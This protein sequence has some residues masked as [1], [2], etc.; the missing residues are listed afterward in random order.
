MKK[1]YSNHPYN[2]SRY[3]AALYLLALLP[4]CKKDIKPALPGEQESAAV[5]YYIVSDVMN[6]AYGPSRGTTAA[7]ADSVQQHG[8]IIYNTDSRYPV[9]AF[10]FLANP[11]YPTVNDVSGINLF[12]YIRCNAGNHKFLFTDVTNAIVA[13]TV[14]RLESNS[15]NSLY[16]ADKP[17]ADGADAAYTVLSVPEPRTAEEGK[18]G[19]RFINLS[20]DAGALD[21]K[22][23]LSDGLTASNTLASVRFREA[24]AYTWLTQE[25]AANGLLRL[26][27]GNSRSNIISAVPARPGRAFVIVIRGFL[28]NTTR[29]ITTGKNADGSLIRETI[30]ISA[31]LR[32]DVRTSY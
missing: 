32:T 18:I 8:N 10:G 12:T 19:V 27:I 6:A 21:C 15:W 5:N 11:E 23:L 22:V 13:D 25:Q 16:L 29:R 14:T 24:S 3:I 2:I 28:H 17:Q 7:Y 26:Q 20:P 1:K 4:A 9:F 30:N 31:G